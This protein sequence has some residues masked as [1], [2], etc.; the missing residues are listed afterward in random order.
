MCAV[1]VMIGY[2]QD[3]LKQ[4]PHIPVSPPRLPSTEEWKQYLELVKKA[5]EF[6]L[7][8]NQPNCEDPKKAEWVEDI[9]KRIIGI[10]QTLKE[11]LEKL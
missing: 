10:E 7:K 6:D 2:G 4:L 1:S 8:T 9:N 5:Q 3:W 11:I